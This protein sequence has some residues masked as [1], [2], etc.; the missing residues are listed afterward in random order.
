[1]FW[2][3]EPGHD[4]SQGPVD[5]LDHA[6]CNPL[7]E[8]KIGL[9]AAAKLPEAGYARR[10]PQLLEMTPEVKARVDAIWDQLGL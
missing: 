3:L 4:I 1:M 5:Q 10:W 2:G 6:L 8:S 7:V 9:D